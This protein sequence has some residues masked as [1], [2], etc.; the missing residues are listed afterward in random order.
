MN[1]PS[2][3]SAL[4]FLV[5]TMVLVATAC[6]PQA[7]EQPAQSPALTEVQAATPGPTVAQKG[8]VIQLT[9][10]DIPEND[11]YV[12][13]WKNYVDQFNKANPDI[14]VTWESFESEPYKQ[15]IESALL[16]GTQPDI[17]YHIP[18]EIAAEHYRQ[19]R[20][21]AIQDLYDITPYTEPG[22]VG[23]SVDGKMVCHPLYI[24]IS[25]MYYN[26]TQ[27]AEAGIDPQKDWADPMQPT[28]DEFI[29]TCDKL[30]A[31]GFVP[32]AMGNQPKWPLMVWVWGGQNRTG[33]AQ[34]LMDAIRGTGTYTHPSFA[35]GVEMVQALVKKD[36]F[37][38]GFNGIGG[39][40][41][42][43]M[44][45]Q[46][47][48][49][50]MYYGPWVI[51]TIE[52]NAPEGFQWGMF[53]FPSV[54]E[55]NPD[56]QDDVEGGIDALWVSATTKHPEAVAKFLQGLTTVDNA[57]SFM[58]ATKFTPT[59]KG[60]EDAAQAAG[61]H[62]A[63]LTLMQYGLEAKHSYPWWDWAMPPEV[64]EEM[65]EMSQPISMLQI[66]PEEFGVR[67][68]AKADQVKNK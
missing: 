27:F 53:K 35:K 47:N 8:E 49:A 57:V 46:G 43:T 13:W 19:G 32:I 68:Q 30:K 26:K 56:D 37:P 38:K 48:G 41:K 60:I 10:W 22:R 40:D 15:K 50:I 54:P 3:L 16:A 12:E 63:V 59:I 44:F 34:V 36:Y 17:F 1:K 9:V 7:T 6:T 2:A 66:T 58:K 29:A 23:C 52:A 20:M 51:D 25:S 64:A 21:L 4:F 39:D 45:T 11:A 5:I 33:G 67:L 55:G 65:L 42:Y 14:H 24:S 31:A 28:W 61:V 62:P 18:G